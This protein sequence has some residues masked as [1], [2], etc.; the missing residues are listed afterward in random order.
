MVDAGAAA[1]FDHYYY[2]DE[3]SA[4]SGPSCEAISLVGWSG[5]AS[6]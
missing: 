3:G 6:E 2:T 5:S 4:C 1:D